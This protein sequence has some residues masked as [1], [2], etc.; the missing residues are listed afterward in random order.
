MQQNSAY[1]YL[2]GGEEGETQTQIEREGDI[3]SER[4]DLRGFHAQLQGSVCVVCKDPQVSLKPGN[5]HPHRSG[6]DGG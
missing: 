3:G 6:V 1:R 4:L 2:E 5:M